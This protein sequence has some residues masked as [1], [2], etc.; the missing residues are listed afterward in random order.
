[1]S[2]R[3]ASRISKPVIPSGSRLS[4]GNAEYHQTRGPKAG[5]RSFLREKPTSFSNSAME[6][7]V[8]RCS[9]SSAPLRISRI[10]S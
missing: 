10:V 7:S 4:G 2:K 8:R 6:S 3:A 5:K 1:L 9:N